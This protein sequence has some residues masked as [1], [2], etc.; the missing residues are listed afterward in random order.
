MKAKPKIS[1]E[2]SAVNRWWPEEV[3]PQVREK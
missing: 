1:E 2:N 3:A